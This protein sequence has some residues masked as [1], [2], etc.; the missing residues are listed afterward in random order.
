MLYRVDALDAFFDFLR[1]GAVRDLRVGASRADVRAALG[2]PHA[3]SAIK[4]LIWVY[5]KTE[6]TF[7]DKGVAMIAMT[8]E[9]D[10]DAFRQRLHMEDL[11]HEPHEDFTCDAQEVFVIPTSGVTVT[12]DLERPLVRAFAS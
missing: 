7:R 3:T 2:E 5:G 9:A 6:I 10:A 4:P 1:S 12:L 8:V 11:P